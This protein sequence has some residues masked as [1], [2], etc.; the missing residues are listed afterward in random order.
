MSSEGQCGAASLLRR[1][2]N[3]ISLAKAVMDNTPHVF[4]AADG[5][6]VTWL[7]GSIAHLS[8]ITPFSHR[9]FQS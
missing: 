7:V 4:L 3:P 6:E 5:A 9:T 1:V 8:V 2:K